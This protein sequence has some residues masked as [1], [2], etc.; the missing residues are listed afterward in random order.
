M[1]E[2]KEKMGEEKFKEAYQEL[3]SSN[4]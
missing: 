2:L 1:N 4:K 3:E